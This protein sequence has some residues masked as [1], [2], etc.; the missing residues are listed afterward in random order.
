MAKG[1]VKW[2]ND[3][4]G[5]LSLQTMV[6]GSRPCRYHRSPKG[7]PYRA[8]EMQS[9]MTADDAVAFLITSWFSVSLKPSFPL[10]SFLKAL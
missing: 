9:P 10:F 4:N 1:T 2:F 6:Q 3:Q 5:D 8:G 7:G